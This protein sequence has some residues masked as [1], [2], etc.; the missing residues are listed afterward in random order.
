MQQGTATPD[1]APKRS[2]TCKPRDPGLE[3]YRRRQLRSNVDFP[4]T[5]RHER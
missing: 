1:L 3:S 2:T 5:L 4:N